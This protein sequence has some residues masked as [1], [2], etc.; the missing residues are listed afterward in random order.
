MWQEYTAWTVYVLIFIIKKEEATS[1]VLDM[2][3]HLQ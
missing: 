2:Q 3:Y 1:N